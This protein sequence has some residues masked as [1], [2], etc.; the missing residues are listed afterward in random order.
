MWNKRRRNAL[1]ILFSLLLLGIMGLH[2]VV[3]YGIISPAKVHLDRTPQDFGVSGK[4]HRITSHDGTPLSAYWIQQ[5]DQEVRGV[6]IFVHGI[7]GCKEHFIPLASQLAKQGIASVVFDGRAHGESGG[8]YCT[9]GFFEKKD[10][11]SVVDFVEEKGLEVPIGIYGNSLGGAIAI[12]AL[13]LDKRLR[14]GIIESTFTDLQQIVF[15]YKKRYLRGIG[16]KSISDYVLNRA[17]DIAHFEPDSVQPIRSVQTIEQ[18]VFIAHGD[19]DANIKF[20]YGRQL[21]NHLAT[22]DKTWYP[23]SGA[24]H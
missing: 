23:V 19:A 6:L 14:F 12:Q 24:G 21:F 22:T 15:D 16:I 8:T 9:Y 11:K 2:F 1:V 13:E 18:P 3:P 10:V 5:H 4:K 17:A 7:G 20:E